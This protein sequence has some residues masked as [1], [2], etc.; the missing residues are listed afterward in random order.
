M[1]TKIQFPN[2]KGQQLSGLLHPA[3]GQ[4]AGV[5][6]FAHC[7]TCSKQIKAA[8]H[9]ADALTA[10]GLMVL[11]FDFTGLGQ[12]EGEFADTHFSH[13][14]QDLLAAADWLGDNHSRPNLL[15]GHSLGG[16]AVLAAALELDSVQAVATI[17]A[18]ADPEHVLHHFED[19][20]ERIEGEGEA[21]VR[22][23]GRP[24]TI[25][26]E[27]IRD[28]QEARLLG[29]L[30]ELRTALLVLHSP[31]DDTV[32]IDQASEI[33]LH[34][35]H[36]KSFVSLDQADHLLSR[37]ADSRYAARVI[38]AWAARYLGSAEDS[39]KG[40]PSGEVT[41]T[42]ELE[43]GFLTFL[44]ADGHALLADE[45]ESYGGTD[46]GPDPYDLLASSLAACT[47]MTM[48]FY[49]RREKIPLQ[50]NSVTVTGDRI[51]AKDCEDCEST[52]GK[53]HVFSRT[54]SLRGELSDEQRQD[55]L[56]VA[57]KCPVHK[58]LEAEIRVRSVLESDD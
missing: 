51:H 6:L 25:R 8:S 15:V 53:V 21:E 27:F 5:A 30:D 18:P 46:R 13:N 35:R 11:R 2:R 36:P 50:D 34:A 1:Q 12:S 10:A 41:A 22:L 57:D 26:R 29:R 49:A 31:I 47:A 37:E 45:P 16:T 19:D 55:L 48:N 3:V 43:D 14:V 44:D 42:A 23:A 20:L 28:V 40:K 9:I 17:N 33:F 38:A 56:R 58:T 54:I 24:F 39:G 52:D 4:L 7:F 32:S